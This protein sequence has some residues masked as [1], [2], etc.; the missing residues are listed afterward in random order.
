M[1]VRG[2]RPHKV[3]EVD[4]QITQ[5]VLKFLLTFGSVLFIFGGGLPC[6]KLLPQTCQL[7]D[8]KAAQ[9]CGNGYPNDTNC[10][11][12]YV[13]RWECLTHLSYYFLKALICKIE[14]GHKNSGTWVHRL[15]K[16]YARFCSH[17][18]VPNSGGLPYHLFLSL[19]C[20]LVVLWKSL[21][22]RR[23]I[24]KLPKNCTRNFAI[25]SHR[26]FHLVGEGEKDLM[27]R[28]SQIA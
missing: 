15:H 23:W 12:T 8:R 9:I 16:V 18:K 25:I 6:L 19:Y 13:L 22:S 10:T 28:Q 20:V 2:R 7:H 1:L 27:A 17:F 4:V 21:K 24:N 14:R 26:Y 3:R 11:Q 5:I